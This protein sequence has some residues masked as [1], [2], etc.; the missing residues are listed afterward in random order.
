MSQPPLNFPLTDADKCV[1]CA[2]CLPHCPTYRDTLD[3]GESPRGRI[4][5][6]QGFATGALEITPQLTGHLD[7][8]LACRACEA[9]CPAEVPYGK[10]I[11][12]ARE[13][14]VR[15]GHKE[16]WPARLFAVCMR[17]PGRLRGLH[18]A[19]WLAQRMGLL[20]LASISPRLAR[21]S[22]LLPKL[23]APRHWQSVYPPSPSSDS[24][25][26]VELFLGCI[27]RVTQPAVTEASIQVLNTLGYDV[28]I[29]ARQVC[30]GALDQ[31]AGRTEKASA[32]AR[33]NLDAFN[34]DA[35]VSLLH[36]ASGCGA[37]LTEYPLLVNTSR[38]VAFSARSS[39]I[40]SFISS[41]KQLNRIRF[42]PWRATVLVHSPCTLK[43]VLKSDKAAAELL[44]H[45]P[46]LKVEAL[47]ANTG[48]CGAA[49]SYVMNE[50]GIADRLADHIVAAVAKIRPAVLVTSNVGCALHLQSALQRHGLDMPL[51]HPVEIL[52]RQMPGHDPA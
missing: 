32:L 4:A 44:R 30:C 41:T 25:Q 33:K 48:C 7:R 51:L 38:A 27:A 39:D 5:L 3:E 13:E 24:R 21:L 19:L 49:G 28:H 42:R 6:M 43:N 50:P 15:H 40:S 17:H 12:A 45:I 46:E 10:L 8:C 16:P 2:L 35:A 31:H 11:D 47:P 29:P 18:L 23:F 34:A 9:V 22:E 14:F 26:E 37:I 20:K 52:A 1:K 36:T